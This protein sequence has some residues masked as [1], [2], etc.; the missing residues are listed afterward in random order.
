MAEGDKVLD[1]DDLV[2]ELLALAAKGRRKVTYEELRRMIAR[3]PCLCPVCL[4]YEVA[5]V[6]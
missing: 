6:G 2:D 4:G 3:R 1:L 5:V